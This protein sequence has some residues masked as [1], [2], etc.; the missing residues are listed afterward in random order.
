MKMRALDNVGAYA[1][2]APFQL[3]KPI[4]AIVGPYKIKSV[5]YRAHAV[6]TNKSGAGS[7][8][9]LRPGADQ[10]RASRSAIDKVAGALGLDRIEVR[11]RNFIRKDEFPYLIPSGTPTTAATITPWSTKCWRSRRLRPHCK[12]SATGCA[13]SGMLAGIGIAACLEPSGGNS[14][15]E[16][17][18]NPKNTT[19][20]LDGIVPHQHRW[21]WAPS[22][23]R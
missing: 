3:G 9:R 19:T 13:R 15:F 5:E 1:G 7:R 10:F 14:S 11:R 20:H 16:P 2:R 17:L 21:R 12:P 23:R 6:T 8:A 22:S 18:L 4:G